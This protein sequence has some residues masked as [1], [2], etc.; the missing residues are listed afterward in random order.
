MATEGMSR[1]S[2]AIMV[3]TSGNGWGML[4]DLGQPIDDRPHLDDA[5]APEERRTFGVCGKSADA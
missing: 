1:R 3:K 2:D 4:L 5:L